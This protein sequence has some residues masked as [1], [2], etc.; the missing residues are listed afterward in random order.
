MNEST[1]LLH[2]GLFVFRSFVHLLLAAVLTLPVSIFVI[3][4]YRA[5]INR[6]MRMTPSGPPPLPSTPLP[7]PRDEPPL[8]VQTV[9]L[10]KSTASSQA[11]GE[12]VAE[13]RAGLRSFG[14]IYAAA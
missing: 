2:S 3:R 12:L 5:A 10:K 11:A 7:L 9:D 6:W 4:R 1:E 8:L 13:A 14:A